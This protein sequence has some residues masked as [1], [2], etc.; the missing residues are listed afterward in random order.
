MLTCQGPYPIDP[1]GDDICDKCGA[2]EV[3][4][5]FIVSGGDAAPV[6]ETVPQA[7]DEIASAMGV[8]VVWDRRLARGVRGHDRFSSSLGD[9]AAEM[10]GVVAVSD[11]APGGS[12]SLDQRVPT[13]CRL[14]RLKRL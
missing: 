3:P 12:G 1:I 14:H 7:L 13:P 6:L 11:Q 5:E 8:G 9:Q 2:E 4:G 10:A